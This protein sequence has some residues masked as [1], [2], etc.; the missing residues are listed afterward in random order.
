MKLN[1][2]SVK[3]PARGVP[4]SL[5]KIG[6]FVPEPAFL[7]LVQNQ[8]SRPPL[9]PVLAANS[10][11]TRVGALADGSGSVGFGHIA[12]PG[13]SVVTIRVQMGAAQIY[14]L[15]D[16]SCRQLWTVIDTWRGNRQ[17]PVA[18]IEDGQVLYSVPEIDWTP[19]MVRDNWEVRSCCL[20]KECYPTD[21]CRFAFFISL[22]VCRARSAR[23]LRLSIF[24]QLKLQ[25]ACRRTCAP[26]PRLVLL[27][28][29]LATP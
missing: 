25:P 6:V 24:P 14:F 8:T 21:C 3:P 13:L 29:R 23:P 15:A 12:G 28:A 2:K 11:L 20:K 4:I 26:R 10:N 18:L 27:R 16:A 17:A 19:G 9:G 1:R 22:M 7:E 5:Q